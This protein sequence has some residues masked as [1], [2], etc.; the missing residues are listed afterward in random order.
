MYEINK[1]IG[2]LAKISIAVVECGVDVICLINRT[3]FV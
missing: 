3:D 1:K 2:L